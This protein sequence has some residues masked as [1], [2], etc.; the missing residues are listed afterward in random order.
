MAEQQ[1]PFRE[2]FAQGAQPDA[3]LY[4]DGHALPIY[5]DDALHA[6]HVYDQ[7]GAN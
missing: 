6:L 5:F 2:V 1:A 4:A 7:T 3:A